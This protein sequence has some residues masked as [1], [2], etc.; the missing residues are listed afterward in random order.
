MVAD[1][2]VVAYV[3][4][5][6]ERA[7][8][9]NRGGHAAALGPRVHCHAFADHA[10]GADRQRRWLTAVLEV[11]R[12]VSDGRERPNF[13]PRANRRPPGDTDVANQLH[14]LAKLDI[15]TNDAERP[16]FDAGAELRPGLDDRGRV[17]MVLSHAC[18]RTHALR[19]Y[20]RAWH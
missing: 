3:R 10:V 5:G 6:E 13:G 16:N 8:V 4:I 1:M 19:R 2:A 17:D 9:A 7:V 12:L 11:L 14:A 18:S 15:G 20:R